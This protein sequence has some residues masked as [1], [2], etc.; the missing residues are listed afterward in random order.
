MKF[1]HST[2]AREI[3]YQWHG[4]QNSPLYAFAS[5]GLIEDLTELDK[6]ISRC[7]KLAGTHKDCLSLASLRR[8]IRSP[9]IRAMPGRYPFVAPWVGV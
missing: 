3:A 9:I 5:S 4:G 6:D 2:K 1:I 8:Y 7:E